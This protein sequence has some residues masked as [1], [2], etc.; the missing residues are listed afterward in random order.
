[1]CHQ[2]YYELISIDLSRQASM[3]ISQQINFTGKLE[4]NDGATMFFVSE[5]QHKLFEV[6]L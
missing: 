4:E 1:M 6:F 5:K 3:S 2:K